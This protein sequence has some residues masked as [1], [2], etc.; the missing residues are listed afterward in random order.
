MPELLPNLRDVGGVPAADG[1][2]VKR[3]MVL[4]SAMPAVGDA[5]CEP[6]PPHY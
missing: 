6:P 1:S 4:R 2:V 5:A 3:G